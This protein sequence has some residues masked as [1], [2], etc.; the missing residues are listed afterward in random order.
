MFKLL[1]SLLTET[2]AP[3]NHLILSDLYIRDYSRASSG[4]IPCIVYFNLRED[5]KD[6]GEL[7]VIGF[8][9]TLLFDTETEDN[10]IDYSYGSEN[11]T[12]GSVDEFIN[13]EGIKNLVLAPDATD[14][15]ILGL[16]EQTVA[17]LTQEAIRLVASLETDDVSEFIDLDALK[18]ALDAHRQ[19]DY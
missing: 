13:V 17:V 6:A 3:T 7:D 5:G 16:G 14:K 19:N 12:H 15:R 11:G 18:K 8:T 10:R 1:S 2:I 4:T 9:G